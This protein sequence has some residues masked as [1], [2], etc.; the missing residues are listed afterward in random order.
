MPLP[1][2]YTLATQFKALQ[3]LDVEEIDERT[4]YDTIEGLEGDLQVKAQN[5]AAFCQNI[6][7][8]ADA[9][10][11]AARKMKERASAI[12]KKADGLKAYIKRSMEAAEVTKIETAEFSLAI[13]KNPVAVVIDNESSIPAGYWIIPAPPAP[14]PDKKA[15][16]ADL[17]AGIPIQ[18]VHLE[19]GT[20]LVLK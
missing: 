5:V 16:A 3:H 12:Q 20:R 2:L 1:A 15:I 4:L 6:Q 17:K 14:Y 19:Q 7:A 9:A 18:G 8:Y 13:Q 10:T 11:E